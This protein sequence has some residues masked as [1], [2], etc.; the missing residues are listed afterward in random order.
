MVVQFKKI[1]KYMAATLAVLAVLS[2]AAVACGGDDD[3]SDAELEK[4]LSGVLEGAF[5]SADDFAQIDTGMSRE[6]AEGVIGP[7]IADLVFNGAGDEPSGADCAYYLN[8]KDPSV[9]YRVCYQGDTV[10]E[11]KE[12]TVIAESP[13]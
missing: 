4:A 3:S 9:G 1:T 5:I 10:A 7:K 6:D 2:I 13:Q 12:F 8:E 11:A